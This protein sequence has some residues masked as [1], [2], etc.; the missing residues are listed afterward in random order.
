MNTDLK[1][2]AQIAAECHVTKQAAY[3]RVNGSPDILERL[4][5]H[6]VTSGTRKYYT[7][8]GQAFIKALFTS[9]QS[10]PEVNQ[11]STE[12]QPEGTAENNENT[13]N[14][15]EESQ[16]EVN[17]RSTISQPAVN[18]KS[19]ESQ[20]NGATQSGAGSPGTAFN[21]AIE[22]LTAQLNAKDEQLK[23]AQDNIKDLNKHIEEL[24][25][26][27]TCSQEQQRALTEA[28]TAAQQSITAAQA[29]HAGTLQERLTVNEEPQGD[30]DPVTVP[31]NKEHSEGEAPA[32]PAE[33][34][35]PKKS[36]FARLF[37]RK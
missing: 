26:A 37:K 12:S 32:D 21:T 8:Q 11:R 23:A 7:L 10:Q 4:Q 25:N 2:L 35:A 5:P 3:K 36:F 6:T 15:I 24:T 34:P 20:P 17:Q 30:P 29:L 33:E 13:T 9:H 22:A 14:A 27:L 19:T 18:Q 1:S 31:P 16:P 28:L